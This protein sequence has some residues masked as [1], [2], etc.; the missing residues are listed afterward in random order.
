MPGRGQTWLRGLQ[1]LS[2]EAGLHLAEF[3][4]QAA[5]P[6]CLCRPAKPLVGTTTS[7]LQ[8]GTRSAKALCFA[9]SLPFSVTLRFP[10]VKPH[11]FPHNPHGVRLEGEGLSRSNLQYRGAGCP[12]WALFFYWENW[13][14]RR[15]LLVRRNAGL[16][17]WSVC[18]PTS[19]PSHVVS[20]ALCD[21][22]G[23]LASPLCSAIFSV[24]SCP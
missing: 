8:V 6:S 2:S 9:G 14:L 16:G 10:V 21:E 1:I 18:R 7:A 3:P 13:R 4:G 15:D 5:P 19:Y 22:G 17:E 12:L 23:A 24:G 20:L 11:R